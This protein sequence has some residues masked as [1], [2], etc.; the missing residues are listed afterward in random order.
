MKDSTQNKNNTKHSLI[1]M[2]FTFLSRLLGII[3]ARVLTTAF[4]ATSTADVINVA[5]FLPNNLRKIFAEGAITS[6]FIPSLTLKNEKT[7]RNKIISLM[8]TFQIIVFTIIIILFAFFGKQIFSFISAFEGDDIELGAILLPYFMGFLAFISIGN[9]F[10]AVLQTDKKFLPYAI[11]P[12]FY[13]ITLIVFVALTNHRLGAMSMAYGVL[14]GSIIQFLFTFLNFF[15]LGYRINLNFNFK[16][17]EFR[18]ILHVWIIVLGASIAAIL[19]EQISTYLAS[20][21]DTGSATAYSNSIIFFSTPYGIITTGFITVVFPLLSRYY[22]ENNEVEFKNS[23]SYGI[24]GMINLFIPATII[25]MFLNE[26]YVGI[27]LQNGKFTYL[28]TQLT[29]S[30]MFYLVSGLTI[31]GI[32]SILNRALISINK[33]KIQLRF[34]ISQAVL[35]ILFSIIL[36]NYVGIIALAIANTITHLIIL[37]IQMIYLKKYINIKNIL[38]TFVKTIIANIPLIIV[39]IIYKLTTDLW[40]I[41]GSTFINFIII[42]LISIFLAILIYLSYHIFKI[43]LISYFKRKR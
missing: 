25:L 36:I 3:K 34:V 13:S 20:T 1:L 35:D 11:A 2:I 41:D 26:E 17:K 28:D 4:G 6:A 21:L 31:I 24:D 32:Y 19:S 9:I 12:L 15:K 16:D 18:K 8:L 7:F 30:I 38:N 14:I 37:I 33:A 40:Y 5:F 23:L 27:L 22:N 39:L 29:A 10:A 43:P 42:S